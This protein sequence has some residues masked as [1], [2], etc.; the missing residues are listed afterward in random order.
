MNKWIGMGRLCSDPEIST[1]NGGTQIA[2][3]RLAIDRRFKRDGEQQADFLPCVAF[4]K[5]AEFAEKYF[6][7]GIKIVVEGRIETGSYDHKDGYKVY[8]TTVIVESHEFAES[9]A[10]S[11]NNAGGNYQKPESNNSSS[12]DGFMNV[13]DGIDEELPFV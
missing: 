9:K 2:R 12:G 8:T 3:Y 1:S 4:G 10:S 7:K 13:P 5:A 11:Q 6:H